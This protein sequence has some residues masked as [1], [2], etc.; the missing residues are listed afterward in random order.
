M[1]SIPKS[2]ALAPHHKLHCSLRSPGRCVCVIWT[3]D[4]VL[5][6]LVGN[7]ASQGPSSGHSIQWTLAESCWELG[8]SRLSWG[9]EAPSL[10]TPSPCC[11]GR[12]SWS[13]ECLC[14]P[15]SGAQPC[16]VTPDVIVPLAPD[17]ESLQ[18]ELKAIWVGIRKIKC[19]H[20]KNF[21]K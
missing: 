19:I 1:R 16:S 14:T 3:P 20:C 17:C 13:P 18:L 9:P 8:A 15:R 7:L 4:R 21:R 6:E 5:A 2:R 10:C 12:V 11:S